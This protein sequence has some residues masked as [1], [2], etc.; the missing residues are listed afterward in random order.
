MKKL[1]ALSAVAVLGLAACGDDDDDGGDTTIPGA[2]APAVTDAIEDAEADITD[3]VEDA[4]A[5]VT[6][7]VED[8]E[9]AVT[10]TTG[11]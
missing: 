6:D 9:E 7:A 2:V 10:G 1:L 8:A 4:E 3:A 5:D 11:G